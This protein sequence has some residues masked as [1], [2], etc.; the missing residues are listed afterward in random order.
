MNVIAEPQLFGENELQAGENIGQCF[1]QGQS[2]GHTTDTQGG[3]NGGDGDAVVLQNH[4][5]AHGVDNTVQDGIQQSCLGHA[6]LGTFDL[7][8][9]YAAD[10]SGDNPGDGQNDDGKEYIGKDAYQRRNDVNGINSPVETYD[11]TERN[12]DTLQGVYKNVLPGGFLYGEMV[13]YTAF[14]HAVD[15]DAHDEGDDQYA[16]GDQQHFQEMSPINMSQHFH[17]WQNDSS[18]E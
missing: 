12:G 9:H 11:Y 18:F 14:Y 16:A 10:G 2:H 1:L 13:H 3:E 17:I 6:L 7:H 15:H 8:I 5:N 4:Q